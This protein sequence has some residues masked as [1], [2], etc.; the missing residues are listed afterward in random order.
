MKIDDLISELLDEPMAQ[1]DNSVAFTSR[2]TQLI[3]EIAELC[4][5]IPIVQET[6]KQA[7]DYAE[8]LSAEQVYVDMLI[9]IVEAPTAIHMKMSAKMLIPIIS[10]KLKERGL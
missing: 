5:G 6:K 8:G 4:N 7:E 2:G 10:R 1:E 3:H 9:K